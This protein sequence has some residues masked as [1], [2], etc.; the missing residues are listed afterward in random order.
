MTILQ[1]II[2]GIVQGI[3]EF[4][5]ISS[6][7]HLILVP[8]YFSWPESGLAFD[9]A[10]HLGTLAAITLYFWRDLL[11]LAREALARG[12]STTMGRLGWGIALGT[13]PGALFGYLMKDLVERVFRANI[14]QIA[15]LLAV[16]G[17]VLYLADQR[18][19]KARPLEQVG[20]IDLLWIGVA[21]AFA[22]IPGVSRSGATITAGLIL[23][24]KRETAARVS[25]LLAWPITLGAGLFTVRDMTPGELA[26]AFWVGVLVSAIS[27]YA[28]IALLLDFLRRG[29]YLLFAGY[30][31]VLAALT[32]LLLY[33]RP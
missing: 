23:G 26:P 33:L 2:L 3:G 15:I 16:M 13:V 5:P 14:A 19:A 12:T 20:L 27:G 10:L 31:V 22:V 8:W 28:V 18:G 21:Q 30:R 4:V 32:L 24:L 29:T 9:L 17:L 11:A 1:A 25:F 6:S 7:A